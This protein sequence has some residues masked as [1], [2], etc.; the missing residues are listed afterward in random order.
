MNS[1]PPLISLDNVTF[2]YRPFLGLSGKVTIPV[3]QSVSLNIHRGD[4]LGVFGRNGEG[5]TTLLRILGGIISPDAGQVTVAPKTSVSLLSL[6]SG[7]NGALTG[8]DNVALT[9]VLMGRTEEWA[10]AFLPQ[11]K[12]FSELGEA[13]DRPVYTYSAGM[14]SRLAFST[15]IN[16]DVDVLLVDE[17]LAVGDASFRKKAE[18]AMAEKIEMGQTLVLVSHSAADIKRICQK[19][20]WLD[21]GSIIE[22]DTVDV[23]AFKYSTAR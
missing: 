11:I 3:V 2:S 14:K 6:G 19:A 15:A 21:N 4:R 18:A 8:K 12:Q 10:R 22:S 5:K 16:L 9:A 1:R 23:V 13:F 17:V 20:I 7:L